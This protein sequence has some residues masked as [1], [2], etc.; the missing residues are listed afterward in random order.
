VKLR[1]IFKTMWGLW[2]AFDTAAV[3]V[4]ILFVLAALSYAGFKYLAG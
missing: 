3:A 1:D 2:D 4:L